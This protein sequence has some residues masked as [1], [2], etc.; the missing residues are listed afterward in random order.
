M[1]KDIFNTFVIPTDAAV[2]SKTLSKGAKDLA[3]V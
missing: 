3:A 1:Y 2:L